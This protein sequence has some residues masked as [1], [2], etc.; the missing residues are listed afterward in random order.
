MK[1]KIIFTTS[2]ILLSL[3]TKLWIYHRSPLINPDGALYLW[4][5]KQIMAKGLSGF[6]DSASFLPSPYPL[7]ITFTNFFFNDLIFSARILSVILATLT[8][9][10]I[11]LLALR[12]GTFDTAILTSMLFAI[13]PDTSGSTGLVVRDIACWFFLSWA[14]YFTI[15]SFSKNEATYHLSFASFFYFVASLLRVDSAIFTI[16]SALFICFLKRNRL[17]GCFY[18]LLP[19]VLLIIMVLI[20]E[21]L[22]G[23]NIKRTLPLE[24]PIVIFQN[25]ASG[26]THLYREIKALAS[27]LSFGVPKKFLTE[28]PN[29]IWLLVPLMILKSFVRTLMYFFTIFIIP[30]LIASIKKRSLL[31]NYSIILSLVIYLAVVCNFFIAGVT[32]SRHLILI[33]LAMLPIVV[34]SMESIMV[35]LRNA[36]KL[37]R[38]NTFFLLSSFILLCGF[39]SNLR[40]SEEDKL[41]FRE[42]G[43]KIKIESAQKDPKILAFSTETISLSYFYAT[44][45]TEITENFKATDGRDLGDICKY[46]VFLERIKQYNIDYVI[47]D[48]KHWKHN[49]FDFMAKIEESGFKIL[50]SWHHKST[51]KI[52]LIKV[53]EIPQGE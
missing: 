6:V 21:L 50:G 41:V 27:E 17:K 34:S 26:Y 44:F 29:F 53:T 52:F 45:D 47:W 12:L 33:L 23:L 1:Q 39:L 13:L 46:A 3:S 32:E 36:L 22:L 9:I 8:V 5:A 51:G 43:E 38:Q 30:G 20:V 18:F 15:I 7:F 14:L 42:I 40:F 25:L 28:V 49:C 16:V 2:V 24:K 37:S 19:I 35:F 31:A 10:P 11:L 48:E 4:Q